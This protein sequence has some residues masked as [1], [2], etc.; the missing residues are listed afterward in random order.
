MKLFEFTKAMIFAIPLGIF[1]TLTALLLVINAMRVRRLEANFNIVFFFYFFFATLAS[2][3]F[4]AFYYYP[5]FF[6]QAEVLY[7]GTLVFTIIFFHQ[8]HC[9]CISSDRRFNPYH[10][11]VATIVIFIVLTAKMLFSEYLSDWMYDIV[12]YVILIY[13]V[14]YVVLGMYEMHRFYV[15]QSIEYGSTTVINHSRVILLIL[16]KLMFPTVFAL[17]PYIG[18]HQPGPVISVLLMVAIL[19]ALYNNIPLVYAI[20][21][22]VTLNDLN[23]SLFDA[24]QLRRSPVTPK[25]DGLGRQNDEQPALLPE[26]QPAAL[27]REKPVALPENQPAPQ[28]ET[29]PNIPAKRIYRKYS[30]DHRITGQLIEIDKTVFDNYIRKNKPYLNPNLTIYDLTE[31]L[32]CNRSYLSKFVNRIYGMSFSNYMNSC[33]L[34]EMNRLLAAPGNRSKTPA[35]LYA[36]AGFAS[37]RNYL[38]AKKNIKIQTNQIKLI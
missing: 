27:P 22:Y 14:Y 15:S 10:Y 6:E 34:N 9:V 20:I 2:I 37:Y 16:E 5:A 17:L 23:R 24:I 29:P 28:A 38:H 33:R 36:Q 19:A 8:F 7:C 21:R 35:T 1:A 31:P 30:Q 11:I 13:A 26:N 3:L 25:D 4:F 12:F 32:Q 18:G